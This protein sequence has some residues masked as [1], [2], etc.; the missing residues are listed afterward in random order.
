M[1]IYVDA[2]G[3]ACPQP[4]LMTKKALESMDEG[5]VVTAV[6]SDIAK[7]NVEK[8]AKSK[9]LNYFI[10]E[11]SSGIEIT[12]EKGSGAEVTIPV[13]VKET[14]EANTLIDGSYTVLISKDTFGEGA[15]ELGKLLLKNYLYTLLEMNLLPSSL[16]FVN[17]GVNLTTEGSGVIDILKQLEKKGVEILSCGT[18][19]DY[20]NLKDKL[21]VGSATNMYEIA[22]KT[23]KM[24][25]VSL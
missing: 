1:E 22:E 8:L 11:R 2:R 19:L 21:S 4:V 12:I 5:R 6:D 24:R 3:K 9:K 23:T 25:T 15:R 13:T 7:E 10:K 14:F 18:C 20:Y 17:K 16:L